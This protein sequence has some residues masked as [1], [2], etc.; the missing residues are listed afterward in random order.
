[1]FNKRYSKEEITCVIKVIIKTLLTIFK[2][3]TTTLLTGTECGSTTVLT[4]AECGLGTFPSVVQSVQFTLPTSEYDS[5]T[6]PVLVS[7]PEPSHGH[8]NL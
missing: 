3:D 8:T 5:I 4:V 1:M 7:K 6:L 2:R